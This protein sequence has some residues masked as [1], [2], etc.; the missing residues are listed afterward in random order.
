MPRS[1][2]M[3]RSRPINVSISVSSRSRTSTSRLHPWRVDAIFLS[4]THSD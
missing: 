2:K 4:G 3:S 1:R